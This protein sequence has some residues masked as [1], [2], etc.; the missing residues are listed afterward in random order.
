MTTNVAPPV[1]TYRKRDRLG[2]DRERRRGSE[3]LLV[4]VACGECGRELAEL[5]PESQ[6]YCPI[7]RRWASAYESSEGGSK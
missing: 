2:R 4:P 3:P 1:N 7:C 6:A 5:P